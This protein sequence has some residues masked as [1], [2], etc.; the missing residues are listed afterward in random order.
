MLVGDYKGKKVQDI[1]K[2]LQKQLLDANEAYIYMEP[3]KQIISR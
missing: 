2:S 1:K 3:E